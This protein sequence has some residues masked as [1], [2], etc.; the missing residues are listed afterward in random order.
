M[1]SVLG[2]KGIAP[3]SRKLLLSGAISSSEVDGSELSLTS[4]SSSGDSDIVSSVSSLDDWPTNTAFLADGACLLLAGRRL[5][6]GVFLFLL[7]D[8]PGL[9]LDDWLLEDFI[10]GCEPLAGAF[11]LVDTWLRLG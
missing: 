2:T 5:L 4:M 8:G 9:L 3:G 6:V 7:P 11:P 10:F 1:W